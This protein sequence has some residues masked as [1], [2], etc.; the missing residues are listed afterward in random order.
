VPGPAAARPS[1]SL[2][3]CPPNRCPPNRCHPAGWPPSRSTPSCARWATTASPYPRPWTTTGEG[4]RVALA[5]AGACACLRLRCCWCRQSTVPPRLALAGPG[6]P[7][8]RC[9]GGGVGEEGLCSRR[10]APA[11][12]RRDEVVGCNLRRWRHDPWPWPWPPDCRHPMRCRH[13][14]LMTMLDARPLVQ[15]RRRVA[16]AG[17]GRAV[18][19]CSA[20][21]PG[22]ASSCASPPSRQPGA[23]PRRATGAGAARHPGRSPRQAALPQATAAPPPPHTHTQSQ[24]P[25]CPPRYASW[26]GRRRRTSPAWGSSPGWQPRASSTAT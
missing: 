2:P 17:G 13:A 23:A 22:A 18:A 14:V 5:G 19:A 8:L 3:P 16:R 10:G 21:W 25:P 1:P 20:A 11:V 9:C 26:S 24:A 4:L 7:G 15:V 6:W 12:G